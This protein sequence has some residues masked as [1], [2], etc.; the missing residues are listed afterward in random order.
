MGQKPKEEYQYF[1]FQFRNY[2]M[3]S[4]WPPNEK[5]GFLRKEPD[6]WERWKAKR[7]RDGRG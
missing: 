4:L 6:I 1:F 2:G 5:R 7:E 3:S